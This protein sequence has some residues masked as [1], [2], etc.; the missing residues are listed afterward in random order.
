[1]AKSN[2]DDNRNF[3]ITS[4]YRHK[5]KKLSN[6]VEKEVLTR[7]QSY[8]VSDESSQVENRKESRRWLEQ[9]KNTALDSMENIAEYRKEG[10]NP[11][12]FDALMEEERLKVLHEIGWSYTD[13]FITRKRSKKEASDTS[14]SDPETSFMIS[15]EEIGSV[16]YYRA[17]YGIVRGI[18]NTSVG[19]YT[20]SLTLDEAMRFILREFETAGKTAMQRRLEEA[21]KRQLSSDRRL[22][23]NGLRQEV[24]KEL[25]KVWNKDNTNKVVKR[26]QDAADITTIADFIE[27]FLAP[28]A[29]K[30]HY[31][32]VMHEKEVR[33][34]QRIKN[35]NMVDLDAQHERK[36]G[37]SQFEENVANGQE[38]PTST[39]R[40]E[41]GD[42]DTP[43]TI[44]PVSGIVRPHKTN[45]QVQVKKPLLPPVPSLPV[46][47]DS[48]NV[49]LD[50]TVNDVSNSVNIEA[51]GTDATPDPIDTEETEISTVEV[52]NQVSDQP[53]LQDEDANKGASH[54][55]VVPD[56]DQEESVTQET[57]EDNEQESGSESTEATED[58][59]ETS[60]RSVDVP[61]DA[62]EDDPESEDEPIEDDHNDTESPALKNTDSQDSVGEEPGDDGLEDVSE[63]NPVEKENSSIEELFNDTDSDSPEDNV[64]EDDVEEKPV[65]RIDEDLI[66]EFDDFL[67]SKDVD[68]SHVN[69]EE[70]NNALDEFNEEDLASILKESIPELFDITRLPVRE[71][72]GKEEELNTMMDGFFDLEEDGMD[73]SK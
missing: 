36:Q 56:N 28:I 21:K 51:E 34:A 46:A 30:M 17:S 22:N 2:K 45:D 33:G 49:D 44:P 59:D 52:D 7:F 67:E 5:M 16:L 55:E 11:T 25:N 54:E 37:E 61:P 47:E 71:E 9:V 10:K 32:A 6:F 14:T 48:T 41:E 69:E 23:A 20:Y 63:H 73:E 60:G 29:R 58:N 3:I 70:I 39:M 19:S 50:E 53:V 42:Q 12:D 43:I 4:K 66:N 64:E 1:M 24:E 15:T 57:D 40:Q 31:E 65:A 26:V 27:F 8:K 68:E 35:Q 62:D 38:T 13:N 18:S 72:T